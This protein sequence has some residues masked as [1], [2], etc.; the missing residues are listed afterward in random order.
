[1]IALKA[2]HECEYDQ[3]QFLRALIKEVQIE[4]QQKAKQL[5]Q[6][7]HLM[8]HH[9]MFLELYSRDKTSLDG[10]KLPKEPLLFA[11]SKEY[12]KHKENWLYDTLPLDLTNQLSTDLP[13]LYL[14][15]GLDMQAPMYWYNELQSQLDKPYQHAILFPFAGHG[16]PGYT[17]LSNG[18]NCSWSLVEQF[19]NTPNN[20]LDTSCLELVNVLEFM[21]D[22]KL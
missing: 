19:I 8:L 3:Q 17:E 6:F 14:H 20:G 15:G 4:Q 22:M 9:Q 21:S 13:I 5:F 10:A 2:L 1:M 18:E 7:N 11:N 16:T 12:L